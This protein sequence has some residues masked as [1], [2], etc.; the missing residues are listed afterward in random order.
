MMSNFEMSNI[1]V[2][3]LNWNGFEDT[4]K[5]VHSLLSQKHLSKIVL[6]DNASDLEEVKQ[7]RE[8][9]AI[10]SRIVLIE[11]AENLGFGR[12]HNEVFRSLKQEG[13]EYVACLNNDAVADEHWLEEMVN[14]ARDQKA[15]MVASLM[16][17]NSKRELVDT[18]GH[19]IISTGEIIPRGQ[20]EHISN[21][22]NFQEV[23]GACAGACLYDLEMLDRLGYFDERFFVGYEDAELG[24]RA[25]LCGYSCVYSPKA[26]V[27]HKMGASIGRIRSANY[28][29]EIQSHIFYTWFKLLPWQIL[30]L[31]APAMIFKYS[32]VLIID[33]V[34]LR[35][36]FLKVMVLSISKS[37]GQIQEIRKARASF[38][39]NHK[40]ERSFGEIFQ[41]LTSFFVFDVWRFWSFVV[42][43]KKSAL[44]Q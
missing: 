27:Y 6:I 19:R 33:I 3:V 30:V 32:M 42:L 16:I 35:L 20:G 2:I 5:A 4:K 11:N 39:K 40:V 31:Q 24:L 10:D 34:F 18:A 28:L 8:F 7:M 9:S 15:S 26:I 41:N 12:A 21:Y 1:P 22:S 23:V 36:K 17:M 43:R 37:G 38:Y 14:C 44:E 13:F 29:S 25:W